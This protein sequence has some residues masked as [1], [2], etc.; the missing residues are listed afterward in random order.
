MW[1]QQTTSTFS[2]ELLWRAAITGLHLARSGHPLAREDHL[3]IQSFLCGFLAF[4]GFIN[5]VGGEIAPEVW[6]DERSFFS[7]KPFRGLEG[8]IEFIFGELPDARVQKTSK[9]YVGFKQAKDLRNNLAH[10]RVFTR[11]EITTS[12][13]H[14]DF[15]TAWE[16]FQNADKVQAVLDNL[17]QLAERIRVEAMKR[18]EATDDYGDSHLRHSAFAG[19]VGT[20]VGFPLY[21][22][23][24]VIQGDDKPPQS[25][26]RRKGRK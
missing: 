15:S 20:S 26:L 3:T 23:S 18:I 24:P 13:K 25:S 1:H 10:N 16:E 7:Q 14:P 2:H 8:K 12:D 21:P 22:G 9:I 4:E 11:T 5:F 6:K 19:P 17:H